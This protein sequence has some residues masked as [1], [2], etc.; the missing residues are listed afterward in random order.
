MKIYTLLIASLGIATVISAQTIFVPNGSVGT[1]ATSGVGI[2]ESHPRSLLDIGAVLGVGKGFRAGDYFEINELEYYNNAVSLGFNAFVAANN[3]T[4]SPTYPQGTGMVL[5]MAGG[6]IGSLD[7]YGRNWAGI[8]APVP[9]TAFTH[10]LRLSTDGR[11][12]VGTKNPEARFD[13]YFIAP[14]TTSNSTNYYTN[15]QQTMRDMPI[16]AGVTDSGYRI[17]F[18]AENYF[19]TPAFAGTLNQQM[20]VFSRVGTYTGATGRI[21]NSYAA[22]L[23]TLTSGGPITNAYG[24]YQTGTGTKNYFEGAIGVGTVSPDARL[25]I[26]PGWNSAHAL[27]INYGNSA[28]QIEVI[29][30][31]ANGVTNG[32]IGIDMRQSPTEGDLWL[33]GSGARTLTVTSNGNVGIGTTNPTQKLSVNGTIRAKE[34]IVETAGWSDYVFEDNYNLAPLSEVEQHIK[35]NKHLPGIPS[36]DDVAAQGI[37]VGEMQAKLL[38]K[39]EELTLHVIRQEKEIEALKRENA[40]VRQGLH[41][42]TA[43]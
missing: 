13:T 1:S 43:Q 32:R 8:D 41:S 35:A 38:A 4:Y 10:V 31:L 29:S 11:V 15:L 20:G 22:Y 36:A 33:G 5:T 28:G 12:G 7:F 42:S 14:P 26:A 6:G 23:E 3:G 16:S 24:V 27:Q 30:L 39:I 40:E 18:R 9:I 25:S 37:D 21:L 17:G 2:N 34:V 19:D